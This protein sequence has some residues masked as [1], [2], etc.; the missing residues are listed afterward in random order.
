MFNNRRHEMQAIKSNKWQK[1][2]LQL[3]GWQ[4]KLE[5]IV[6][7]HNKVTEL[8]NDSEILYTT[9]INVTEY[10]AGHQVKKQKGCR[11][12]SGIYSAIF[13]NDHR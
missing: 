8:A 13:D 11:K 12:C 9:I 5:V 4:L 1:I 3:K 6:V 7:P 2:I 10:Y